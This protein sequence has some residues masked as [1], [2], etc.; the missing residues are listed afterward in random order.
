MRHRGP[1]RTGWRMRSPISW[2][3]HSVAC[4]V[5]IQPES[6]YLSGMRRSLPTLLLLVSLVACG[7]DTTTTTES[8]GISTTTT[9]VSETT[10]TEAEVTTT[11]SETTTTALAIDVTVAGGVVEGPD[12]FEFALG[13]LVEITVLTDVADEIHV[14]GY[15]LMFDV[16]PGIPVEISFEADAQGIFEVELEE[17]E[18]PLFEIQVTP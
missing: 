9:T 2:A 13:D 1:M 7:T 11:L 17:S 8:P 3:E 4:R 5:G 18:L 15:D 10:S 12:R 16:G 14:H 6:S